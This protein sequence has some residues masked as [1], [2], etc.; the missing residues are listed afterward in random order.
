MSFKK[1]L[2]SF[3]LGARGPY[4]RMQS[5]GERLSETLGDWADEK[6]E[7]GWNNALIAASK[8]GK[9]ITP[10]QQVE[11]SD[12]W[13]VPLGQIMDAA[14]RINEPLEDAMRKNFGKAFYV[15]LEGMVKRG[16]KP[17]EQ[18]LGN[19]QKQLRGDL[20]PNEANAIAM[21]VFQKVYPSLK[22][23]TFTLGPGAKR[24][25][26]IDGKVTQTA[27][28]VKAEK[29]ERLY[30]TT[31]GY[32]PRDQAIGKKKPTPDSGGALTQKDMASKI[33]SAAQQLTGIQAGVNMSKDILWTPQHILAV[34]KAKRQLD[35]MVKEYEE[36]WGPGSAK[37]A[38]FDSSTSKPQKISPEMTRAY[39]LEADGDRAK[40][41]AMAIAD[42]YEI[43]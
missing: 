2:T 11:I 30:D 15:A 16:D 40:A 36:Q 35:I 27:E 22:E 32:L 7:S 17:T 23:E 5:G 28:N 33:R 37:T 41:R 8:E 34:R 13:G 42:G 38:G 12:K 19:M 14:K 9:P 21:H 26:S 6:R 31:E 10:Q 18:Q 25:K 39:I 29:E 1:D 20:D 24:F 4:G 3:G 43:P